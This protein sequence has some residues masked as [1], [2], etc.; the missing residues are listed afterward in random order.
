MHFFVRFEPRPEQAAE[1]REELMRAVAA[2]R[3]EPGCLR[4]EAF[5]SLRPPARFSV[6]SEWVEEAAFDGHTDLPHT[7]RFLAAAARL[8]PHPVRGLRTRPLTP[9]HP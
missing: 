2:T 8:L 7:V 9:P 5:E 4:I 6:H 1:F 3:E